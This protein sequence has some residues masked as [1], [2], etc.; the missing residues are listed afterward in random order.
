MDRERRLLEHELV[1][2]LRRLSPGAG[3][4]HWDEF[5]HRLRLLLDVSTASVYGLSRFG[6]ETVTTFVHGSGVEQQRLR[7]MVD[8]IAT[9]SGFRLFDPLRVT[10][11]QANRVMNVERLVRSGQLSDESWSIARSRF[12]KELGLTTEDQLRVVVTEGRT[13]LAWVGGL[14]GPHDKPFDAS[15]EATLRRLLPA[16]RDRLILDERLRRAPLVNAALDAALV[17]FDEPVLLVDEAGR[18]VMMNPVAQR[19]W[20]ANVGLRE[21]V[22]DAVAGAP[23]PFRVTDVRAEG[24]PPHRLLVRRGDDH[25]A[26]V[27]RAGAERDWRLTPR[28]SSVLA[29]VVQG[30]TNAAIARQLDCAERTVELHVTRLLEKSL[31]DNRATLIARFWTG[32]RG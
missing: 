26:L 15:A 21:E 10:D 12:E 27:R 8:S 23:G 11:D 9:E 19:L 25:G 22:A 17:L 16:I 3:S 28:E 18:P 29:L 13:M 20:D 1:A 6:H 5:A 14:R 4:R 24:V 7:R 32:E 31:S 30:L 2:G